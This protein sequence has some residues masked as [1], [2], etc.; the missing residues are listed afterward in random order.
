MEEAN[1][2]NKQK[3]LVKRKLPRGTSEYQVCT[4]IEL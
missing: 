2:N 3:K 1:I 4:S